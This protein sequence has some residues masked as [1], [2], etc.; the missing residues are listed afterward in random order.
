VKPLAHCWLARSKKISILF[1]SLVVFGAFG[2]DGVWRY[3]ASLFERVG[4]LDGFVGGGVKSHCK[5][6]MVY[7]NERVV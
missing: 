3:L 4:G 2:L 1:L 7:L 6:W 5:C